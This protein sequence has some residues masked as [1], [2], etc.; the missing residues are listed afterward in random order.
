M[1][2]FLKNLF[3]RDEPKVEPRKVPTISDLKTYDPQTKIVDVLRRPEARIETVTTPQ[4]IREEGKKE[5][6]KATSV[7]E[8]ESILKKYDTRPTVNIGFGAEP[9]RTGVH[10]FLQD[11]EVSR[12]YDEKKSELE[13]KV[14]KDILA[15][16]YDMTGEKDL[17]KIIDRTT[18]ENVDKLLKK[19]PKHAEGRIE[20][21]D[22]QPE[23]KKK[24]IEKPSDIVPIH[25]MIPI[26]KGVVR[27]VGERLGEKRKEILP[28]PWD[29]EE[30]FQPQTYR[31]EEGKR[32]VVPGL[33]SDME[34][35]T[36][37]RPTFGT[38]DEGEWVI[39][40]T[41]LD[42]AILHIQNLPE[43]IG[44]IG[45]QAVQA[46]RQA[47]VTGTKLKET[48]SLKE[49]WQKAVRETPELSL[50]LLDMGER[51]GLEQNELEGM[52]RGVQ[53]TFGEFVDKAIEEKGELTTWDITKLQGAT[54][55]KEVLPVAMDAWITWGFTKMGAQVI[56]RMTGYDAQTQAALQ[57]LNLSK[58][59]RI[60][61]KK[62]LEYA[63]KN[64]NL[65]DLS[66]KEAE[67]YITL[68][69][70]V[71][72]QSKALRAAVTP[73]E[74]ARV[75]AAADYLLN[76]SGLRTRL[77][78]EPK[79]R[80]WYDPSVGDPVKG[81][82]TTK[83][84]EPSAG[85]QRVVNP[86]TGAETIVPR[87]ETYLVENQLK[88]TSKFVQKIQDASASILGIRY[89][90]AVLPRAG[91]ER[92][93]G[94]RPPMGPQAGAVAPGE[95]IPKGTL[96]KVG[97]LLGKGQTATQIAN[98]L[99][100]EK[101]LVE[102]A[103]KQ[104]GRSM[105]PQSMVGETIYHQTETGEVPQYDA[106]FGTKS[107]MEGHPKQFGDK[108]VEL[109]VPEEA[110]IIN[111][112]TESPIGTEIKL[113]IG[114]TAW[115][116]DKE[117]QNILKQPSYKDGK[118]TPA[119]EELYELWMDKKNLSQ[120]FSNDKYKDYD[121]VVF[122]DEVFVPKETI[123][124]W[125]Q[126]QGTQRLP[127]N[128]LMDS[129]GDPIKRTLA[130]V[131]KGETS[132][133]RGPVEVARVQGG[134]I[135][136]DGQHRAVQALKRGDIEIDARILSNKEALAKY[137][138]QWPQLEGVLSVP[139]PIKDIPTFTPPKD[140]STKLLNAFTGMPE[141][142]KR[143]RFEAKINEVKSKKGVSKYDE[144]LVRKAAE[145]QDK[146]INL[147]QLSE[148]IR[149]ELVPLRWDKVKGQPYIDVTGGYLEDPD[150]YNEV[151]YSGPLETIAG[152]KHYRAE[153]YPGYF[154]Q[155]R[156]EDLLPE[157]VSVIRGIGRIK[158]GEK[159]TRKFFEIQSDLTQ[160]T[161]PEGEP[162]I[163][164]F[165]ITKDQPPGVT[166]DKVME[167]IVEG[168]IKRIHPRK[169]IEK[170]GLWKHPAVISDI[171]RVVFRPKRYLK[172]R[173]IMTLG[174]D[175]VDGYPGSIGDDILL[176]D[177]TKVEIESY[178]KYLQEL[179]NSLPEKPSGPRREMMDRYEAYSP[180]TNAHL[181]TF[182]EE[183]K[184]AAENGIERILIPRGVTA[185]EIEGLGASHTWFN[186]GTQGLR[187]IR[188]AGG[189]PPSYNEQ[190]IRNEDL[191]IGKIIYQ[192]GNKPWIVID[193]FNDGRFRATPV[194]KLEDFGLFVDEKF[195]VPLD[196]VKKLEYRGHT[197]YYNELTVDE[198]IKEAIAKGPGS[199]EEQI[200]EL[201]RNRSETF[202]LSN[203]VDTKHFV[204]KLNEFAIPK[205][206]KRMGLEVKAIER[207]TKTI[208]GEKV[209]GG[210]W[211]QIEIPKEM[212][213]Y[214]TEAFGLFAGFE[215]DEEGN[216]T[217]NPEVA[218]M[219]MAVIGATKGIGP[220]KIGEIKMLRQSGMTPAQIAK[221]VN[222]TESVIGQVLKQELAALAKKAQKMAV[223]EIEAEALKRLDKFRK[224]AGLMAP[225]EEAGVIRTTEKAPD[226]SAD[227]YTQFSLRRL[228]GEM[229]ERGDQFRKQAHEILYKYDPEYKLLY[230]KAQEKPETKEIDVESLFKDD[231]P[232]GI[233]AILQ[234]EDT[235]AGTPKESITDLSPEQVRADIDRAKLEEKVRD[236]ILSKRGKILQ[237]EFGGEE[238]AFREKWGE[239][240]RGAIPWEETA[241]MAG[242]I[243][244]DIQKLASLPKGTIFNAET[245]EAAMQEL[246]GWKAA[247]NK[248][249]ENVAADPTNQGM[250]IE[251]E[252][253]QRLVNRAAINIT[254]VKSEMGRALN[255][256]QYDG[257][258]MRTSRRITKNIEKEMRKLDDASKEMMQQEIDNLDMT[259]EKA[260]NDFLAK[261]SNA[262]LIQKIVEFYKTALYSAP[263]TQLFNAVSSAAMMGLDIPVRIT[264]GGFDA[265]RAKITGTPREVYAT[266]AIR[267]ITGG[268]N[269]LRAAGREGLNSLKEE[270]YKGG[271]R[272]LAK[273]T[274]EP[275]IEGK[276]VPAI[277]GKWFRYSGGLVWRVANATDNVERTIMM[278][279]QLDSLAYRIAKQEGHTG[280]NLAQ[281]I[282]QIKAAPPK[283][284]IDEVTIRGERIMGYEDLRG[285]FEYIN[286]FRFNVPV[287]QLVMP[288]YRG[289]INYAFVESYRLTPM[290]FITTPI[291]ERMGEIRVPRITEDMG[292]FEKQRIGAKRLFAEEMKTDPRMASI[293]ARPE[294]KGRMIL[295]TVIGAI[296]MG[297][298]LEDRLE[299]TGPAPRN[300]GERDV[301]YETGKMPY[302][303]RY[304]KKDGTWTNWIEFR[305]MQPWASIAFT[306]HQIK[307]YKDM[308]ENN[309]DGLTKDMM[310]DR[311][312]ELLNQIIRFVFTEQAAMQGVTALI[313]A[314]DGG[315]Y[316]QGTIDSASRFVQNQASGF[317]PNILFRYNVATDP[318]L[319][320][321]HNIWEE[322]DKR[323]P[324][325]QGDLIPRRNAFGFV[326]ERGE[327]P[328]SRM[329]NPYRYSK[330]SNDPVYNE[331]ERLGTGIGFPTKSVG[332]V[333]LTP[334]EYDLF[335]QDYGQRLYDYLSRA[336]Q[337]ES[338]QQADNYEKIEII[339]EY[340][341]QIRS[342][343]RET[344][345]QDYYIFQ[346]YMRLAE[347]RE[348]LPEEAY[349]FAVEKTGVDPNNEEWREK[350][351]DEK[352]KQVEKRL[353]DFYE[354][355]P[356]SYFERL[357]EG[358]VD[359]T[360]AQETRKTPREREGLI[361]SL[362]KR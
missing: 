216:V 245:M 135:V 272:A 115:P 3:K 79:T 140:L 211:W 92:A 126:A 160:R 110:N 307:E 179:Q 127:I 176:K 223:D 36:V 316:N 53:R 71:N 221:Q 41:F 343:S 283:D 342:D 1:L 51:M 362:L 275:V 200:D 290:R 146:F 334:E 249:K 17:S 177:G 327:T 155:A 85:Y 326:I 137:K 183:V 89:D 279:M 55:L 205:E 328:I 28:M 94:A 214:P 90:P 239:Q 240:K 225:R 187:E 161:G 8:L 16:Y 248:M 295:G 339:Q 324:G 224:N 47:I 312:I 159:I 130:K 226:G 93:L 340:K 178:R 348:M 27:S 139:K 331:L 72:A 86:K 20:K 100:I 218:M 262:G 212:K 82:K 131:P 313:E 56:L 117:L 165:E 232:K 182:R 104:L 220:R 144:E 346:E 190:I 13:Q 308:T 174:M 59:K 83:G 88:A 323:I 280:I 296:L 204:Y 121:I 57:T 260:V 26:P 201:L 349:K 148:K 153:K 292:W 246:R 49:A 194:K 10:D 172:E 80:T 42:D 173:I 7:P 81:W 44:R 167:D 122:G 106:F 265:V 32:V 188:V 168:M 269:S 189:T 29:V 338:Y 217:Y 270:G 306:L 30:R 317:I 210:T 180:D 103:I 282:E 319:Y 132:V 73:N 256:T 361:E 255:I 259:N 75:N 231:K 209:G 192:I 45:L 273:E 95:F 147:K 325:R 39:G 261:Y 143:G 58:D 118:I 335:L 207:E 107:F 229:A 35:M 206:A 109:R 91:Y 266:E 228:K 257:S 77:I 311:T 21:L 309:P 14:Q 116:E 193:I 24:M 38:L 252:E 284:L 213:D 359:P 329:F 304:K 113:D 125:Q 297:M 293:Y 196:Q 241:R 138:D 195:N 198:Y 271:A 347:K 305:R 175:R 98:T 300:Q 285:V 227:I 336:I 70:I 185:M 357:R 145:E 84:Y 18:P 37:R 254:A 164:I 119:G 303:F 234:R 171:K 236:T 301:F 281:R 244:L 136:L 186:I 314:M 344:L 61:T 114:R 76:K 23:E 197:L 60:I 96:D 12:L 337:R 170:H 67:Q 68:S 330:P 22:P 141:I 298:I 299:L 112:N 233:D 184:R 52:F 238:L 191:E 31:D 320:L 54:L 128:Q 351:I 247:V 9:R 134:Y 358:V 11:K 123:D 286:Q 48:D 258:I 40:R 163:S 332:G 277:K 230:D 253:M 64:L 162:K 133:T 63:K 264:A 142:I 333:T 350:Y 25:P 108:V 267:M 150:M 235:M 5:I 69:E 33:E 166:S 291:K 203:R 250:K 302:A 50:G 321:T 208:G 215:V 251:L 355:D 278:G 15:E 310:T 101:T 237:E 74:I 242:S 151:I 149:A 169:I 19:I 356:E 154:S 199:V 289:I 65:K 43:A 276:R 46:T 341:N 243:K 102:Q 360:K 157:T 287:S 120:A 6:Q 99:K 222:L 34:K 129:E 318:T 111:L 87:P 78:Y 345:F 274:G 2:S 288:F 4:T 263:T 294:E 66:A 219:A 156:Y 105:I 354:G 353:K 315:A 158:P 181:R 268:F 152:D 62:G 202:D 97:A 322:F 352:T 124:K